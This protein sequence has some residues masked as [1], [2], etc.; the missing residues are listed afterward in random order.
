MSNIYLKVEETSVYKYPFK[1]LSSKETLNFVWG[2][3]N[4]VCDLSNTWSSGGGNSSFSV[5][6]G[7]L[8]LVCF[9][10]YYST[11]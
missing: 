3:Y 9:S 11:S 10:K 5:L 1:F 8:E 7:L 6:P 2:E 4:Y